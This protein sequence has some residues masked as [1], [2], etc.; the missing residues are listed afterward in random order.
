[1]TRVRKSQKKESN[2][3]PQ[4]NVDVEPVPPTFSCS[5]ELS[6]TSSYSSETLLRLFDEP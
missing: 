2:S 5:N 3:S 4:L 1:M 6:I